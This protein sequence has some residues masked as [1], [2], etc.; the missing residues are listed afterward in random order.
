M[1]HHGH[2]TRDLRNALCVC[3]LQSFSNGNRNRRFRRHR[4]PNSRY[5]SPDKPL[6]S[7]HQCDDESLYRH[8]KL[9]RK[10]RVYRKSDSFARMRALSWDNRIHHAGQ[11]KIRF[12]ASA[13][14]VATFPAAATIRFIS[15]SSDNIVHSFRYPDDS[16]THAADIGQFACDRFKVCHVRAV[17]NGTIQSSSFNG[18]VAAMPFILPPMNAILLNRY[19]RPSSP[20][21]SAKYTSDCGAS[22]KERRRS[23]LVIRCNLPLA[24]CRGA[25]TV[26]KSGNAREEFDVLE[27]RLP[28]PGGCSPRAKWVFANKVTQRRHHSHPRVTV[29]PKISFPRHSTGSAPSLRRNSACSSVCARQREKL[30]SR[31]RA[32]LGKRCQRRN[33]RGDMRALTKALGMP[34]PAASRQGPA[35]RSIHNAKS[36]FQ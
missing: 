24:G 4:P 18:V 27:L 29:Q 22:P 17:N 6:C 28:H 20:S 19:S 31:R 14:S 30:L 10:V 21:V 26:N 35:I 7:S 33:V 3:R 16:I 9:I 11:H 15:R 34:L 25:M 32:L 12:T 1:G 8:Q 13:F 36:G 2:H 23:P 5:K